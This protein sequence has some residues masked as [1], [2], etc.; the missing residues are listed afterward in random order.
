MIIFLIVELNFQLGY[1]FIMSSDLIL[2]IDDLVLVDLHIIC[3]FCLYLLNHL[4]ELFL[5]TLQIINLNPIVINLSC[6]FI[7]CLLISINDGL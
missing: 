2:K 7:L 5:F 4:E 6:K 3:L 1:F